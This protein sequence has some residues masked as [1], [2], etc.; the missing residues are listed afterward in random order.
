MLTEEKIKVIVE[1]SIIG[2]N[3][4][5][6]DI[7]LGSSNR[8]NVFIDS[9][10]GITINECSELHRRII[11]DIEKYC[12]D[13]VL[14]VSSPGIDSHF[15]VIRQY[16][17]NIGKELKIITMD[18]NKSIGKLLSAN[19]KELCL[20]EVSNSFKGRTEEKLKEII[21]IKMNF[22]KSAKLVLCL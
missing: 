21:T 16:Q 17:K 22:I 10:E 15:K 2:S 6:V 7:K 14:Q 9:N 18:G 1:K 5:I 12:K 4:F 3:I 19:E 13:F 20:E 8:V 11:E